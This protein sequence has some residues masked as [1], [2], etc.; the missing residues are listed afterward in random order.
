M[1]KKQIVSREIV[2]SE[3]ERFVVTTSADGMR[4][5][6]PVTKIRPLLKPRLRRQK[7]VVAKKVF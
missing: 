3:N 6:V 7:L 4:L 5:R 1:A 2:V